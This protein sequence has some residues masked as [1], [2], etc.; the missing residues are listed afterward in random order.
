MLF[1]SHPDPEAKLERGA[2]NDDSLGNIL[3]EL[4]YITREQLEAA[5]RIQKSQ[6]R[7]GV[8]L[9]EE[10]GAIT[11]EQLEE[12]LLEQEIRKKKNNLRALKKLYSR[13]Q[14]RLVSEVKN[15]MTVL[16]AKVDKV[17]LKAV[18]E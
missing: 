15:S 14:N 18:G 12:A 8:I 7:L 13:K 9:V 5:I 10:L 3:L 16:A 11:T 4:G 1:S 2:L 6:I 17:T